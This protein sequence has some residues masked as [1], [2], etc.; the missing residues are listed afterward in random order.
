MYLLHC[1]TFGV[2][3]FGELEFSFRTAEGEPRLVT[4]VQ[5]AG[6]VGKTSLLQILAS[7]RPG[8]STVLVGRGIPGAELPPFAVSEWHLG[9]DDAGRPHPL[10]VTTPNARPSGDEETAILRR[11]EQA[12]FDRYAKERGGFVFVSFSA[13]R[14][15]SKQA[16]ALVSPLRTVA[17][18]DVRAVA[19]FDDAAHSD[20]T[21]DT[22]QALA[23]AAVSTALIPNNQRERVALRSSAPDLLD[24]RLLGTAM[25]DTVDA[26]VSLAG[27]RYE[28]LDPPSMEPT[29][30]TTGGTRLFFERLPNHVRNLVSFAAL[31]VRTLWAAYPG[32]D[33]RT[34]EGVVA[35]DEVDLHQDGFV[36]ERLV[37]TLRT[38]LPRVQ[39]ILTTSSSV[40]ASSVGAEEVLALRRTPTDDRVELFVGHEARTH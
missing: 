15:F 33:P 34:M 3:P 37:E 40:L 5:G 4:V 6:G 18:Y 20:L 17:S 14:W 7:T 23:Y 21:R 19:S 9:L 32:R 38:S 24:M 39:W 29:F 11:R 27:F 25:R 30:R 22:K 36:V 8:H 35:I 16:V 10:V 13:A 1:Q 31:P 12:L 28:G 2:S 26:L